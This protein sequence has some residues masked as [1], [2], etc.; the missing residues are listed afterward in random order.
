MAAFVLSTTQA[1][2]AQVPKGWSPGSGWLQGAMCVHSHESTDWHIHNPPYANGFQFMYGTWLSAGG[3]PSTWIT[4]SPREQLYRAWIVWKR[5]G[6][7][8]REWPN[9]S[10]MCGLR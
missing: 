8:W 7:S 2:S 3:S 1:V 10:R 5:D 6:Y 9:T 4:A